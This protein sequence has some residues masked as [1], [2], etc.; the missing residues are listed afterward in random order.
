MIAR[1]RS[2]RDPNNRI[3]SMKF[4]S[5]LTR[6][7]TNFVFLAVVYYSLNLMDKYQQRFVLAVLVLVYCV[8][9]AV[10]AFRAFGFFRRIERLE[11]ETRRLGAVLE[12]G[13]A[14]AA[15][16]RLLIGNVSGPRRSAEMMT[17]MDL[18]FLAIIAVLCIAKIVTD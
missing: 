18:M 12:A 3:R 11:V 6:F 4:L 15:A 17:Y 10:N 16:R 7:I 13:P 2:A 1:Y 14:D 8:L 5:Y 9:H